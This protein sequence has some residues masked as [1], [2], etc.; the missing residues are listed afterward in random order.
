MHEEAELRKETG[1]GKCSYCQRFLKDLS[2]HKCAQ[3][4][5]AVKSVIN[6]E[7]KDRLTQKAAEAEE[8]K[9]RFIDRQAEERLRS[10]F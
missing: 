8:R 5:K 4:R 9:K 6:E 3:R 10:S 1:E 2:K 7:A